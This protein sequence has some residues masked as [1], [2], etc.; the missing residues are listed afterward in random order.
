[1]VK[2]SSKKVKMGV[3]EAKRCLTEWYTM[4]HAVTPLKGG[5]TCMA[6]VVS[7]RHSVVG[8]LAPCMQWRNHALHGVH[9]GGDG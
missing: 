1:M 4:H 5:I 9:D 8:H 6:A 7:H 2:S 3:F